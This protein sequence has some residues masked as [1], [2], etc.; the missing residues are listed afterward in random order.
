MNLSVPRICV[1]LNWWITF[2]VL[3]LH[4]T[5]CYII[6]LLYIHFETKQNW[7]NVIVVLP[8]RWLSVLTFAFSG[9]IFF[10]C[11]QQKHSGGWLCIF[12]VS[13]S[14]DLNMYFIYTLLTWVAIF[15]CTDSQSTSYAY[16]LEKH[17]YKRTKTIYRQTFYKKQPPLYSDGY[18][19]TSLCLCVIFENKINLSWV[20]QF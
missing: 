19:L 18:V 14:F 11:I 6:F 15:L 9:N 20:F 7:H 3:N 10:E 2:S 5:L 12:I 16:W 1:L 13:K 4:L 17:Q 8:S